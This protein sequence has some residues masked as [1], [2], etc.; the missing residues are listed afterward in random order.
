MFL[1]VSF[2]P[3]FQE[4]ALLGEWFPIRLSLTNQESSS[5]C[6]VSFEIT[7]IS[8]P[9]DLSIEQASK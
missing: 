7:L 8:N 9:E 2:T 1:Q 5:I 6:N 3:H 4:P